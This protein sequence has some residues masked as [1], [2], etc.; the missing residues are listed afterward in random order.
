MQPLR[1]FLPYL[2]GA[3]VLLGLGLCGG[4]WLY[5]ASQYRAGQDACKVAQTL[6]ELEQFK[7]T[8]TELANLSQKL[9]GA[10]QTLATAKP[11]TIERYTRVEVQSPLPSGCVRDT[12][13]VRETNNAIGEANA[14]RQSFGTVPASAGH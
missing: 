13:R 5:G 6:A 12:G 2:I 9:E 14:A 10:A 1:P 11:K 8:S 7:R 3:A 4:V